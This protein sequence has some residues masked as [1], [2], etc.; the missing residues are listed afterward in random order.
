VTTGVIGFLLAGLE[1]INHKWFIY[2]EL[3]SQ[4]NHLWF[5]NP[6]ILSRQIMFGFALLGLPPLIA[7]YRKQAT[8]RT[9]RAAVKS[10]PRPPVL[11]LRAFYQESLAFTW[12]PKEVMARYTSHPM[13]TTQGNTVSITF[14]QYIDSAI[15]RGIGPFVALGNPEDFLPPEGASREYAEDRD[16]QKHFLKLAE[17]A[18]AI[19]MEVSRSDNLRWEI[20]ALRSH[21]WQRKL[22][23]ITPPKP[24][25]NIMYRWIFAGLRAARGVAAPRW[26]EFAS[27]LNNAGFQTDPADPGF[28][29][30]V[31][32]DLAGSS[33]VITRGAT[34]PEEYV[35]AIKRR[36]EALSLTH[37]SMQS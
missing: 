1:Y 29:S 12:G 32:F 7:Y 13:T 14:E 18:S 9:L 36:L 28:G 8:A 30:V 2:S 10:D 5:L 33:E 6:K 35:T 11:Y 16:W 37:G 25:A 24:M 26:S 19:V 34:D 17:T 23:V 20:A 22:F 15:S 27:E 31:S 4:I 3:L 21:G